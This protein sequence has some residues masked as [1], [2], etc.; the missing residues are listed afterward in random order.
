MVMDV[1][2]GTQAGGDSRGQVR[3]GRLCAGLA[4]LVLALV[5]APA[6][7][8]AAD[9][10]VT[11]VDPAAT[12]DPQ[13]ALE[14]AGAA[15][16]PAAAAAPT[17]SRDV[18]VALR[19][20]ALVLPELEGAE[21]REA[22]RLLA[23]PTDNPDPG[24]SAF[25]VPEAPPLCTSHFCVH[26][27]TSTE[28]APSPADS[29]PNGVPDYVEKI[30]I[31]A[32]TSYSVENGALGWPAAKSDGT[33]GNPP[34]ETRSGLVDIYL[35]NIGDEG[36]FGYTSTDP[37]PAQ[38][39]RR[40][41]FAYLVLDN[42][43]SPAEFGYQDPRIPL[44]VTMA[45]EYNHVLQFGIDAIQDGWLLESTAVWA[46][47]NVFPADNDYLNYLPRFSRTP[48]VPITKFKGAG[49]LRIYGLAVFQHWLDR[50]TGN[51]GPG[52]ILG[53]WLA[54]RITAPPDFA[55]AA[56]DH[57]VR[58]RGGPGFAGEF[59][60]FAAA[61]AE[62]RT[63]GGFPDAAAYPDVVRQGS[64]G[65]RTK[66]FQLDHT[67]YRLFNVPHASGRRL[68]LRV[69]A[70]RATRTSIALV[71]RDDD[72]GT[73]AR[74]VRLLKRGGKGSVSLSSPASFERITAVV[75]NADGRTD[76]FTGADWHYTRDNR[77][78]SARL[79]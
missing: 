23:R 77:R 46:E 54:S 43:F 53:S 1:E 79:G 66:R 73:V 13:R 62:W 4:A 22:K 59:G 64:L 28:D 49:G 15:L 48:D 74:R 32:E 19:D 65:R 55:V 44:E 71:G 57:A 51:Y 56:V 52:V 58:E 34:G 78:F 75:T 63:A 70:E 24:G 60:E 5:A 16:D 50:G 67:T 69:S 39:C 8:I 26:Y 30:A 25:R 36:I 37:R 68:R 17:E 47:E 33:R 20:L 40:T 38:D 6:P 45:H 2:P 9:A 29:P 41:C 42:D 21:R 10:P 31:A 27:V 18:T 72:S 14:V 12:V 61:S 35:A 76:G 11:T 3:A 7:A